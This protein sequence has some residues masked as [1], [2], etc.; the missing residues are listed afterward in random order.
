MILDLH[1]FV[2]EGRPLWDELDAL[3]LRLET[4]GKRAC[5]DL[6]EAKRLHYLYQRAS[7]DLA[8]V[9]TFAAEPEIRAHLESLVGRAYGEVHRHRRTDDRW[10]VWRWFV[11][12]FPGAF[13]RRL[14]SFWMAVVATIAG[15]AFGAGAVLFDP[16]AKP[17]LLPFDHLLGN[18]ADRVA[19]EERDGGSDGAMHATFSAS[20]MTHNIRVAILTL[21]LGIT[22]GFGT[23]VIIFYNG[24]ILGAVVAD[25]IAAGQTT[26]LVGWLLPHGSVEIPAFLIAGQAGLVLG[27]AL[28]GRGD[29]APM[30]ERLRSAGPDL[31]TLI[32][33]V[34]V[35]LVW[36][37]IVESF[38][39]QYHE[40]VLPY[41]AKITFGAVQLTLLAAFLILSGRRGTLLTARRGGAG[42]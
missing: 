34:A 29:R 30:V 22:W 42:A 13:R 20:L 36:A 5:L 8:R 27:G 37:G 35:L 23:L 14:G 41:A 38:L 40:P 1:H 33:G 15:A 9:M 21:A 24:V 10:A 2:Q 25:Y 16:E 39:S 7:A 11:A 3:L 28:I 12:G 32:G 17:V 4:G 18:P 26:F 19:E 31:A 6:E